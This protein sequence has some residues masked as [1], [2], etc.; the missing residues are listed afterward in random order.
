MKISAQLTDKA[1]LQELGGRLAG[2][3]I[4]HNL[5]QAALAEQAGVSKRTIERLESGEVAT[6]LSGF[7]RV[8]RALGLLERFET[9]LPESVPGPMAQ[10]KQAGRKR[11]RAT[12]KRGVTEKPVKWTW[13]EPT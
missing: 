7:L 4:E 3:R 11:Q 2:L 6:Q 9:L 10:L 8:C 13:G 1:V 12:G 5:T